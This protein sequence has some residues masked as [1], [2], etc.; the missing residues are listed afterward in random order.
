M[1]SKHEE[2]Q[3]KECH[4]KLSTFMELLKHIANEHCKEQCE[5]HRI[6]Y[7]DDEL[8]KLEEFL[9]NKK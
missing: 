7:E 3:C 6:E 1:L 4:L 8:N 5:E 2:H 9:V